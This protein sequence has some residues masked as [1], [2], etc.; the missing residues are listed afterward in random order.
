MYERY[1]DDSQQV[2]EIEN[3]EEHETVRRLHDI[4]NNI[5]EDIVMTVD[6]PENFE[7]KKLPI[8]DMKVWLGEEDGRIYYQHFEKPTSSKLVISSRSAHSG[9][10]KRSVHIN[11]LVR[12]MSNTSQR[13]D[14]TEHVAPVLTEYM[15]RMMAAGYKENYR[16]NILQNAIS[17]FN[18]KL[19]KS[20]EGITPLNRSKDYRKAERRKE[21][22]EKKK[23]WANKDGSL[24]PIIVPATPGGV[25][26]RMLKNVV[27][28]ESESGIKFKIV[29]R[30]GISIG[31]MLQKPNPTKSPGCQKDDCNMCLENKSE[32]CHKPNIVYSYT[33]KDCPEVNKYTGETS[34]NFYTRDQEHRDPKNPKSWML[35]HQNEEHQG[36]TPN[37][38]MKVEKVFKDPLSRQAGEA[39]MIRRT[40]GNVLNSKLEFNQPQLFNV[41]REIMNG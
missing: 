11:E 22:L 18:I 3:G 2:A 13:L 25:L 12:R 10:C 4:A 16:K 40:K 7:D 1:V 6:L 21:K 30:G 33:C 17:I 5:V 26:A 35:S 28:S 31:K 9:T 39:V 24:A 19:Q 27:E 23:N 15:R 8:L 41:R 36:T 37:Y 29:E 38:K 32:L 20:N 34:R 14:W